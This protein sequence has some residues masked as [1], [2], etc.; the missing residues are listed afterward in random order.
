MQLIFV[1]HGNDR[2]IPMET[3]SLNYVTSRHVYD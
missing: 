2:C 3:S 1:F